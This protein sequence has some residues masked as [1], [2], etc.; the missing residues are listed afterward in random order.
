MT[1]SNHQSTLSKQQ[2]DAVV[3]LYSNGQ[4]QEA[5][6]YAKNKLERFSENSIL[7]NI[8]GACYVELGDQISAV[9]KYQKAILIQPDYAKAHYNLGALYHEM[10]KFDESIESYEKSLVIDPEYAEAH[11]NLANVLREFGFFDSAIIRYKE[12]LKLEPELLELL[13]EQ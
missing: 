3:A 10:G 6:D 13:E 5:I 8:A 1:D 2:I 9:K 11:N 12:A 4:Y 7:H